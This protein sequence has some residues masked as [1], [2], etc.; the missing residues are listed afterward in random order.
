MYSGYVRVDKDEEGA[1]GQHGGGGGK[2]RALFYV[3]VQAEEQP[4]QAPVLLWMTG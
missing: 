3:M 4:D 2:G 1:P